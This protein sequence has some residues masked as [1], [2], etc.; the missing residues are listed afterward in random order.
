MKRSWRSVAAGVSLAV[1]TPM[2]CAVPATAADERVAVLLVNEGL[3]RDNATWV[4]EADP[5]SATVKLARAVPGAVGKYQL[6][7]MRPHPFPADHPFDGTQIVNVGTGKC[8]ADDGQFDAQALI[9]VDCAFA[10][11]NGWKWPLPSGEQTPGPLRPWSTFTARTPVPTTGTAV[12]QV[13]HQLSAAEAGEY[14]DVSRWR[15][16]RS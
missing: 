2:V 12:A 11:V 3:S 15:T 9:L 14:G 5:V 16:V 1:L 6:W 4:M 7:Q 10:Y 8:L 13:L